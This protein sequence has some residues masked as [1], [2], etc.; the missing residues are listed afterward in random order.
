MNPVSPFDFETNTISTTISNKINHKNNIMKWHMRLN[1]GPFRKQ[2]LLASMGKI[3]KKLS[4]MSKDNIPICTSC[5]YEK[6]THLP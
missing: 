2:N 4:K 5:L 6:A 3:P 1:H